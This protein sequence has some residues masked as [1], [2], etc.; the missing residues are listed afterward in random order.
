MFNEANT[1]EAYV[2]DLLAGPIKSISANAVQEPQAGYGP[3]PK[4]IG[5]RYA[6]P[7]E[8]PRQI[9]EVLVEPWL[10]DAL[11][12]LNPEIAAQ[13]DRADE[14][15]YKLRAIVLS[16][17]SDGL[18]RANE[19]M[20]A[21]MR[22][23]RSMP[24][25]HNNEHVPVRL[26]DLDDLSQNLYIVT[27][28]YTYRAG[29]T[30]RRA[31]LVLL[32]N[33]LPLVL[34]EAKT[35]VKKCISWVDGAVQVHDDYEKFVPELFV[36]N[37]F[38]VATEGKAYHYG[39]IGLPVKDW[40]PWHLD[41][42]GDNGQHHP[43][44]SL[45]LSAESML[46]PRVVLDI[47][48]SFTLFATDKK[49]RR[50]KIICRYQQ[51]EAANKIVERVLAGYP[52]KGLIWHFQGSGKSLLMVF[53]AQKLRMHAGLKNPTVLIVVDRIDLD[54]QITGTFT[55]ADIPNLEKADT[56]EKLQQ[57]LAQDVRKIIIT[58]IFKFGEATGSLN[59][60]SNIIALVDEAHRT[61]EGDLGRKMREALPN[62]FLFGLTGTPI[63]RAD[64]N[65]FYAFG[66]DEDEKGYMSRYGF[67]ESIRDGATLKLHFEPRLIDLHI[68]KAALDAAYKDLTGGLSDLDKDNLAKTAAKMA[69]LVKTPERIRKV[70]EDIVEHFQTKVEP[71][72]FKG[73]IVTFDRES[74]LLFKAEL[75][76]LLPPEAT[77]IVMSVQASDKKEHPEYAAYDRSRDEEERLL[78]RFRDPADPLK[79]IIVTAKLLTGFDAPILQAMYLDKPLRDHTLLQAICRVNRTYSEQKTH[80]LIVDYL[81]IFDDVAAALEFDDQSVKQVVSN[82]QELKDKLPEAMQ[83]CLAFFPGIDR[84][85]QGYEG[86]MAAQ[87]CLPNNEVRDNFASEYTVLTRIWEALS[88]DAVL[89]SFEKDY[90]W[91]SQVYQS[92]QPS[93]GHGKLI[94][95]SLGAKTI[96][97]IHQNV[98]VDAVRD[99][100]ETLVLDADLLEAVLSNPDPKKAK[101][102]EIKLKRRLREHAG[103]PKFKQL[104]ERLDALKDRFESGQINSVEFLKQL[105][106]I[107]KETLQ[108]EKEVPPEEDEDRGKAA[109][110]ELF[111]EVK[112]AKTPIMVERVVADIDEIVRLVRFPGWQG[113]QAGER[114]VK[115]ALRKALFKYKLHADE[116]LFEKAYSY[117]RQYY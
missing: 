6:A 50:I 3:S 78:D 102:I 36:C 108:A 10:R 87:E 46:R 15:L 111:N 5:W 107:A 77:D 48:G 34:I 24:F 68:D 66:A 62:A 116:E 96:E 42:D 117:I 40:G 19:E 17:R 84:N 106:E 73:Q 85:Q 49:K 89:I 97:L 103:N 30:E 9:Q 8:V 93:S 64:R 88:P 70:C 110:T 12:R 79:L 60:R 29:P 7:A 69:V 37:V 22:G 99:D 45:K 114:E 1:V 16:V 59:D 11:I 71:N 54:T 72:G 105:L 101:E 83:K 112:T 53:A 23:E 100:L 109:L 91:L 38:S 26:I 82:I 4:G 63:N 27:Q 47:L 90:K 13:P 2:R 56:R 57:L 21:W 75:D 86:L 18:I 65:T 58:T 20:T 31:D 51:F 52:R 98:H 113:T 74:C 39:S 94:W 25:G 41:G 104:S 44:K 61:Q 43:L 35:P 95:H 80:G 28:Q 32:V 67:E 55:G 33:G 76:K 14:V 92:V 81:G 115:K